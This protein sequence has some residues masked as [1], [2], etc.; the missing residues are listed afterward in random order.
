[1]MFVSSGGLENAKRLI[2][3]YKEN[4]VPAMTPELWRAKKIVDSSLH[5]GTFPSLH[6]PLTP[7]KR[8]VANCSG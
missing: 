7:R 8:Q 3:S 6:S 4:H 2:S 5:P 1:M